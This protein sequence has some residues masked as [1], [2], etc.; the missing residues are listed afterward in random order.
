VPGTDG[1]FRPGERRLA[2]EY[3]QAIQDYDLALRLTPAY[4]VAFDNRG[5]G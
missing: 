5:F 4:A 3:D 2:S 1:G